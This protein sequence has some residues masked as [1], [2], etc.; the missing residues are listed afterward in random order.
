MQCR[1]ALK[2][3]ALGIRAIPNIL[4]YLSVMYFTTA[5]FLALA[6]ISSATPFAGSETNAQRLARGLAPLPPKIRAPH[7]SSPVV[8]KLIRFTCLV[9]TYDV[10]V[11]R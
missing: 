1:P 8:R 6:A 7:D 11:N 5:L 4:S 3:R 2:G 10:P 9:I